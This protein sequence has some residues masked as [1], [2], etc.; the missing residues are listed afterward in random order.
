MLF[1]PFSTNQGKYSQCEVNISYLSCNFLL[2]I[3]FHGTFFSNKIFCVLSINEKCFRIKKDEDVKLLK[4]LLAFQDLNIVDL[5]PSCTSDLK[6]FE[7]G[8][9][10]KELWSLALLD[11]NDQFPRGG[12]LESLPILHYPGSMEQCLNV[13]NGAL[14]GRYWMI[15]TYNSTKQLNPIPMLSLG[16]MRIGRCFPSG[17]SQQDVVTATGAFLNNITNTKDVYTAVILNSHEHNEV[18]E[19]T[20][21]DITML[22]VISIIGVVVFLSTVIDTALTSFHIQ[23]ASAGLWQGFSIYNNL[24][25]IFN[26]KSG[27]S[28]GGNLACINGIRAISISWVVLGHTYFEMTSLG[29]LTGNGLMMNNFGIFGREG[30][31]VDSWAGTAIWNGMFAVD[32]FF[33]IGAILLAFHTLKE[34]DKNKGKSTKQW[35]MFWITFYVHRY[36]RLT[37]VYAIVIGIHA[38][39]LQHFATGPLSYLVTKQVTKCQNGWF[40]NLLYLNNF[41]NTVGEEMN[42]MGW[43]WYMANDMQFFII[44]PLILYLLWKWIPIGIVVSV[45]LL[46]IA[47]VTPFTL[48]WT[49]ETQFFHG[50]VS[51]FYQKPWNRFQ[52]YIMGLLVGYLLHKMRNYSKLKVPGWLS[53]IIW[54]VA[55]VL[56]CLPLYGLSSYNMVK[57]PTLQIPSSPGYPSQLERSFFNGLSKISWCLALAW[58]I[59]SSVKGRGGLV[60][61]FLSWGFWVP[62]ARLSY[63]IYLIQYTVVYW[64]NSQLSYPVNYSNLYLTY[65]SVGNFAMCTVLALVLALLFEAPFFHLEKLFFGVLG[66]GRMPSARK[67]KQKTKEETVEKLQIKSKF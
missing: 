47:T 43:T 21:G 59:V 63:C 60:N 35:T 4:E 19:F 66:I 7:E 40:L 57:D 49:D 54:L 2:K 44:T 18:Y 9:S 3:I 42:C 34:M 62:L 15:T 61:S 28:D 13:H 45:C 46:L 14:F 29:V 30:G 32:S 1:E 36:I 55:A 67:E 38:T 41:A 31:P 26:T 27:P 52:P 48:T 16:L 56:A 10:K 53:F 8:I 22:S 58:V 23:H 20:A 5:S 64:Q 50:D 33:M 11:A 51:D 17:C 6:A 37:A 24:T 12:V 39:L 65:V 25:K